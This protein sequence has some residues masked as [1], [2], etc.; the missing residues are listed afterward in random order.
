MPKKSQINECSVC[1]IVPWRQVVR[2]DQGA[3]DDR[4]SMA[5]VTRTAI[6]N[7][8]G[9]DLKVKV[10]NQ[11][12]FADLATVR[13]GGKYTMDMDMNG[14]YR[15]FQLTTATGATS[16]AV[17]A[18]GAAEIGRNS[19]KLVLSSDECCD[20]SRITVKEVDGKFDVHKEPRGRS[21]SSSSSSSSTKSKKSIWTLWR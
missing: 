14:T 11:L 18:T 6:V 19:M 8:T 2:I 20:Y 17:S 13:K 1:F 12:H 4:L 10:G 5:S 16:T 15:E 7:E 21:S 3:A 9:Q